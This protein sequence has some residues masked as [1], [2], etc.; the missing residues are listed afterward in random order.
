MSEATREQREETVVR[1]LEE[2]AAAKEFP[3]FA[4]MVARYR[5]LKKSDSLE[6]DKEMN[7]IYDQLVELVD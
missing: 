2:E 7:R 1:I 5:K 3:E 4:T 6:S